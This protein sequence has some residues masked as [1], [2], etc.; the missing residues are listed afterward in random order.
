MA[1]PS[2]LIRRNLPR[3]SGDLITNTSSNEGRWLY[4]TAVEDSTISSLT[5]NLSNTAGFASKILLGGT[6]IG[7]MEISEIT[8]TSGT[9]IMHDRDI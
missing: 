7:P 8:L 9:V 5:T 3:A 6:T 2:Q 4:V 1:E